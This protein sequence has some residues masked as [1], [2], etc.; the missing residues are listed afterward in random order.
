[1]KR[2]VNILNS[3]LKRVLQNYYLIEI[4]FCYNSYGVDI[5]HIKEKSG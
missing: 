4:Y 3:P 5:D 1:M 2:E